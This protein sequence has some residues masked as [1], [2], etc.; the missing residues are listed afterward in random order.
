[1]T[2]EHVRQHFIPQCYLR[3]FSE[4]EKFV[5]VYSK[6][7]KNKGYPQ[8]IAKTACQDYFYAIPDKYLNRESS[9][10]IDS[11]FIEKKVLAENIESLYS[12]L[13]NKILQA[14]SA[15]N[16]TEEKKEI[17]NTKDRDLQGKRI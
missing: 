14:A 13:L 10:D 7:N 2:K 3:N 4:N 12:K 1:M 11:N 16:V 5:F 6:T 15:W 9:P 17:L 8:S